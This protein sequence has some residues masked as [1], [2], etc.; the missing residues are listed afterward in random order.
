VTSRPVQVW[1]EDFARRYVGAGHWTD[2]TLP[3]FLLER[4]ESKPDA[5]AVRDASSTLTYAELATR[6]DAFAGGLIA[7]G[8]E[9]GD[10]VLLQLPN[11]SEF[12][13]AMFGCMRADVLPVYALPAHR[14]QEVGGF[15]EGSGARG[16]LITDRHAGFDYR[17]LA[18]R[19]GAEHPDLAVFVAGDG[20][21]FPSFEALEADDEGRRR[22]ADACGA[23]FLQLSGG[24]TGLSKLIPRTH[25]DYLYS[26][27][28]SARIC[29]LDSD[30]VYL[31]TLPIAHNFPMSSPGTLGALWAGGSVTL[32]AAP[33][34]DVAFPLIERDRVTI[35]GVVPPIAMLWT[36]AAATTSFDISSLQVL[37]VGGARFAPEAARRVEPAL[38]VRLQQVYGMAEGLVNYT[39]LDDPEHVRIGTQGRPISEDDELRIVDTEG[40]PVREGERGQLLTRGPYTIRAYL[41]DEATNERAFTED[42]FYCTG[43]LVSRTE[44]G[45][46][47]VHGRVSDVVNRGGEKVPVEEVENHLLAHDA[48]YDAVV[49]PVADRMLGEKS[50]AVVIQR[51]G[52][53]LS[54]PTLRR[55]IRERGLAAYKVP[56]RVVFVDAFPETG[57]GKVS[58][59]ELR[60]ALR[61]L[62]DEERQ[63]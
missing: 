24:S 13:I 59:T 45:N 31:G 54:A 1:P 10:R 43:D 8:F 57:V 32:A 29:R 6:A 53:D 5:V 60:R 55:W 61:R 58:R 33:S 21:E 19:V 62:M 26:V 34:P 50:C 11:I 36:A 51:E 52:S 14:E 49:V 22:A 17:E 20:E 44:E 39:R 9:A 23:A 35:T 47:V 25:R 4:A 18:R 15:L 3:G 12:F 40:R 2:L 16:Y 48:V 7:R 38:G 46:L 42:G 37:Q 27:R 63:A 41:A 28:E 56:D 30:T